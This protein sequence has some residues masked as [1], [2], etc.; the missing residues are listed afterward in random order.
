[1]FWSTMVMRVRLGSDFF[2]GGLANNFGEVNSCATVKGDVFVSYGMKGGGT[3]H[4]LLGG[5]F[6]VDTNSLAESAKFVT[7]GSVRGCTQ[8]IVSAEIVML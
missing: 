6:R 1:M 8:P 4:L 5:V 3:L 2:G 7:V